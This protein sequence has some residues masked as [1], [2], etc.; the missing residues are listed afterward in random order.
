MSLGCLSAYSANTITPTA[1][2]KVS[3]AKSARAIG[4]LF[5]A[6]LSDG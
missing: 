1:D 6:I 4:N 2:A 3:G 5:R